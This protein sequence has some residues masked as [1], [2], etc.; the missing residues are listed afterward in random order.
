[1]NS[2]SLWYTSRDST[3]VAPVTP[4]MFLANLI[5]V[6][7]CYAANFIKLKLKLFKYWK[8]LTG[9]Y[10]TSIFRIMEIGYTEIEEETSTQRNHI[11]WELEF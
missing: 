10:E 5:D 11:D 8:T 9:E 2:R 1:M 7:D 3:D 6:P 4:Y